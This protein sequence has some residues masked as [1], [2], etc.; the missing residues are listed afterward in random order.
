[1]SYT[2]TGAITGAAVSGLTSPTYTLTADTAAD[3]ASRQSAV[4]N[5]GG[6]QTGVNVHSVSLPFTVTVTRPKSLRTLGK[7]NLNGVIAN[8]GRNTYGNLF[9][10]GV[11]PLAGQPAQIAII[12]V[13]QEIPAGSE[14]NDQPNLK[15]LASF[16][17]GFINTN[18][19]GMFDTWTNAML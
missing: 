9:R 13:N 15:A 18:A 14:L 16:T 10:K 12:R 19:S 17:G 2:M 1:M 5:L 8:V 3:D 7:A 4:T 6:T 11:Y